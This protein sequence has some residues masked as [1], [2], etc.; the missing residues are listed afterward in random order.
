MQVN[1]AS[2]ADGRWYHTVLG[3]RIVFV[4][5][6][7][8]LDPWSPLEDDGMGEI[9]TFD[10]ESTTSDRERA[11]HELN[12]NPDAV[13]LA[14]TGYGCCRGWQVGGREPDG[15]W[16]PD[17]A[18][19]QEVSGTAGPGRRSRMLAYAAQACGVFTQYLQGDVYG[20]E[21]QVYTARKAQSGEVYDDLGDYRFDIALFDESCWGLYGLEYFEQEVETV[22]KAALKAK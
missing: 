5:K 22:L 10:R 1:Q 14:A 18:L 13:P 9:V 7:P 6:S 8:D 16:V 20:Y 2:D 4:R 21:V 3:R 15:V 17:Q 11:V 12:T 19:L